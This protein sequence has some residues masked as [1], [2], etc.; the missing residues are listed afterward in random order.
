MKINYTEKEIVDALKATAKSVNNRSNK[1]GIMHVSGLKYEI[2]RNGQIYNLRFV[3][4]EGKEHPIDVN[5][6]RT[7][8]TY[9]V[10]INDFYAAGNDD[11]PMLNK[12]LQAV[13]KFDYDLND[14]VEWFIRN[15]KEPVDIIDDGRL[16]IID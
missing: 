1:P 13:E 7:D 16:K 10:A 4:R 12:Q 8:K 6:P 14:C 9:L 2:S 15:H 11:L 5:N 3:D